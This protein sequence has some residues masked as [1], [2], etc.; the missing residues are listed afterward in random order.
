MS[1]RLG[2]LVPS[3][4]KETSVSIY[5]SAVNALHQTYENMS[6]DTIESRMVYK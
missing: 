5:I 1:E 2:K 4:I 3:N 6:E